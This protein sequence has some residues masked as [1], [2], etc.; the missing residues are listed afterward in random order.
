MSAFLIISGYLVNIQ[1]GLGAFL[2]KY[3]WIF[4]PYACMEAGYIVMSR[5]LPVR[6]NVPELSLELLAYKIFIKPIGPYWYLHT[7]I[8]CS[9]V[10][11]AIFHYS[12]LN[13][14]SKIIVLGLC[15][16]V[17]SYGKLVVFSNAI[18]FFIGVTIYQSKIHFTDIFRPTFI[19][20]IPMAILCS[21]PENLNRGSL[22]GITITYLAISISLAFFHYLP[23][24]FKKRFYFIGKNTLVIF[25]F[26]PVFTILSR[27]F[28]P[29]LTFEPSGML[30][31]IIAVSFTIIGSL[32]IA[33]IM[34]KLHLSKVFFGEKA[35]L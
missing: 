22:A 2:K 16:F 13:T 33:W 19:A 12:R 26:S 18:Y 17:I 32:S 5:Y 34:D 3:L 9:I 23:V 8:I 4:I 35:I 28:L 11:Y 15:L 14:I 21:F 6:E 30:F 20:I 1:K 31:L 25:L 29:F 10:Y 7:L 27:T 24:G